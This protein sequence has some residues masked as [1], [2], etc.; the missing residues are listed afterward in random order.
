MHRSGTSLITQW[1]NACGLNIGHNL[2]GVGIG[3]D[4]GHF[5]DLDFVN[6]HQ[7]VLDDN[8]LCG[9]GLITQ[10]DLI[11]SNEL[12]HEFEQILAVKPNENWGWKDPRTC[13]FLS[14]YQEVLPEANY[15]IIVRNYSSVISSLVK[16]DLKNLLHKEIPRHKVVKTLRWNLYKKHKIIRDYDIKHMVHFYAQVYLFYNQQILSLLNT[17]ASKDKFVVVEYSELL[18]N[19]DKYTNLLSHKF[20]LKIKNI[21][22]KSIYK[23][24]LISKQQYFDPMIFTQVELEQLDQTYKEIKQYI[25]RI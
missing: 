1:L 10:N 22:F 24:D 21:D 4:D 13:L 15:L 12:K 19:A 3:N 16:R 20:N 7:H 18:K 9:T 8:Q 6:W 14:H 23:K 11:I 17:P 5:E 2:M 25:E